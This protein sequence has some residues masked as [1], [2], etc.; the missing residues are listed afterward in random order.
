M[1]LYS[2]IT[3]ITT[4]NTEIRKIL[5]FL[6]GL[7]FVLL[8]GLI[9]KP[10]IHWISVGSKA[11]TAAIWI[12][13]SLSMSAQDNFSRDSLLTI[14]TQ[15]GEAL[16][17][18]GIKPDIFM[19]D[20]NIQPVSNKLRNINFNGEATDLALV[21]QKITTE[22][23]EESRVG[24]FIIT[25]GVVTRGEDPA[26]MDY[27]TTFPVYTI[28]IGDSNRVM[29]PSVIKVVVPPTA[30][31]GDTVL[32]QAE[33][34][35]GGN[36]APL[37]IT[38]KSGTKIVQKQTMASQL[39]PLKKK[40]DFQFVPQK[41]G[42]ELIIVEISGAQDKNPYNNLTM[43]V[44]QVLKSATRVLIVSAQPNFEARF[45]TNTLRSQ[46]DFEISN[47]VENDGQWLS[48]DCSDCISKGWDLMVFIG[49][50]NR[51]SDPRNLQA[52]KNRIVGTG[53]PVWLFLNSG[54]D[55]KKIE[56]LLGW[57]PVAAYE[58]NK[59]TE[60][61]AVQGGEMTHPIVTNWQKGALSG[62]I[63]ATLPPIGT[64]FKILQLAPTFETLIASNDLAANP[65][66]AVNSEVTN[67]LAVCSGTDLW[68]WAFLGQEVGRVN[69]Y[70]DLFQG[71]AKWLT[72]SLN[73][74]PIQFSI[75]KKVFLTGE[76]IEIN[77]LLRDIKGTLVSN[78]KMQ[79]ELISNNEVITTAGLIWNG[80][81]YSGSLPVKNAGEMMVRISA[82][83]EEK[84]VAFREQVISV[85]DRPVELMEVRQ[86][87]ELLRMIALKTGGQK[88]NPEQAVNIAAEL[89][90][91][92][93]AVRHSH[94]IRML[95]WKWTLIILIS[96]LA[97]EWSLRRFHGYQ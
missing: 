42:E 23:A 16:K 1:L 13:N 34:I 19:F 7:I 73:T 32:V 81:Q 85:L 5:L 38:L 69:V 18:R 80:E 26:F 2:N 4:E 74:S 82:F 36:G 56:N 91:Q 31:V 84:A 78:A 35:P 30:R 27:S 48:T 21:L 25:D 75:N 72:D 92:E 90:P 28:G 24:A 39:S 12:D 64:D 40:I 76:M 94:V 60:S 6:R 61:V 8:S 54:S 11:P 67:R 65:V 41:A 50:P 47:I 55:I 43:S 88:I 33:A 44:L 63:I 17:K 79:V 10:E 53:L 3:A 83:R 22:S 70:Q 95:R 89:K 14:I 57:N 71:I 68:R 9:L 97:I 51:R 87:A 58:L 93:K 20:E 86:N 37:N 96:L 62:E 45:L 15:L 77:G 66:I 59:T 52:I 46:Q 29:D 49:Y